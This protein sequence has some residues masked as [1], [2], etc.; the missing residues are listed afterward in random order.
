MKKV[1]MVLCLVIITIPL[2]ALDV[3][4]FAPVQ[5]TLFVDEL[6]V[7]KTIIPGISPNQVQTTVQSLPDYASFISSKKEEVMVDGIRSTALFITLSFSKAGQYSINPIP[8]R[9]QY[10]YQHISFKIISVYDNP[11]NLQP[12][13]YLLFED[14]QKDAIQK[15]TV[16]ESA[17][18]VLYAL[19]FSSIKAI[20]WTPSEYGVL[21]EKKQLETLPFSQ[22]PF[23]EK[24]VPLLLFD[25]VPLVEGIH[26]LPYISVEGRSWAENEVTI[27]T[28]GKSIVVESTLT[29]DND[30]SSPLSEG[31][32]DQAFTVI[33]KPDTIIVHDEESAETLYRKAL[34]KKTYYLFFT[35]VFFVICIVFLI[36]WFIFYRQNNKK[37]VLFIG[38]V[39][40]FLLFFFCFIVF[41][42]NDGVYQGGSLYMIPETAS[43]TVVSMTTPVL[44]RI[45]LE[46]EMWMYVSIVNSQKDAIKKVGWVPSDDVKKIKLH[47]K[48]H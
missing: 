18:C 31:L 46:T 4:P 2:F 22:G 44:V 3:E 14:T 17:R 6:C 16:G 45:H 25:Y 38:V 30:I 43:K 34:S 8:A 24:P 26:E 35:I 21:F 11:R 42:L 29:T 7:F 28:T 5:K 1:S 47:K 23:S 37:T 40:F 41:S 13:V 39:V 36:L 32:F 48:G 27:V 19:Y 12:Q 9:I 20:T 33:E 10:G 15:I